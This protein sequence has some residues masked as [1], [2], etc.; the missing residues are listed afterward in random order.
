MKPAGPNSTTVAA[1]YTWPPA[2][3]ADA[4][5]YISR[6]WQTIFAADSVSATFNFLDGG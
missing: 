5:A 4:L 1:R 3:V 2:F 6:N